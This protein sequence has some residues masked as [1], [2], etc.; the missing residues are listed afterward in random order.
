MFE[1][2][3]KRLELSVQDLHKFLNLMFGIEYFN[4]LGIWVVSNAEWSGNCI[5]V[6]AVNNRKN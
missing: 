3:L 1:C 2:I 6:F 4:A 5:C